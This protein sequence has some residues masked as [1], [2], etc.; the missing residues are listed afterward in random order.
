MALFKA[1]VRYLEGGIATGFKHV[2]RDAFT[3]R[4]LH[5]K[6]RRAVRVFQVELSAASMNSGMSVCPYQPTMVPVI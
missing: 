5:V 6:G 1:G 2:D 4:L 3:T